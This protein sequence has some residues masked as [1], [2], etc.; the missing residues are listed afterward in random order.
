MT[1]VTAAEEIRV[2]GVVIRFLVEGSATAGTAALFEFDIPA[3][4]MAPPPHSHERWEETIYGV[5]GTLTWTVDGVATDVSPGEVLV[6]PRGV[7]H[8]FENLGTE[9]ATQLAV[10][11]PGVLGPAYFRE[12]AEVI[13]VDGPPD[14]SAALEVMRRHGLTPAR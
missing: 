5:R 3:G 14:L 10:I 1:A 12:L 11:T 2:G 6:I 4:S 9:P 13:N 8:R 7:V